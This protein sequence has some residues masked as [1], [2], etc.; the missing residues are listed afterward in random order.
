VIPLPIPKPE[1]PLQKQ[2]VRAEIEQPFPPPSA[3]PKE[4]SPVVMG[5]KGRPSSPTLGATAN[6]KP[7]KSYIRT[8]IM[9]KKSDSGLRTKKKFVF[10]LTSEGKLEYYKPTAKIGKDAPTDTIDLLDCGELTL[11]KGAVKFKLGSKVQ[12]LECSDVEELEGWAEALKKF[13]SSEPLATSKKEKSSSGYTL[14]TSE[15]VEIKEKTYSLAQETPP[16]LPN[17]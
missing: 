7:P 11:E 6:D 12:E 14:K 10:M 2:E 8:G 4:P 13:V 16:D 1:S 3:T 17:E 9:E 5:N 15:V